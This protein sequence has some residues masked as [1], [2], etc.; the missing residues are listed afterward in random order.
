[1]SVYVLVLPLLLLFGLYKRHKIPSNT[2]D[3]DDEFIPLRN[4]RNSAKDDILDSLQFLD[5]NYEAKFWF[6]EL[7]EIARKFLLT[8]GI[9]YFG[10]KSLSGV[11][12]A[13]MIANVFLVLHAHFK[14]IKRKSEQ[15]LQLLSLTVISL[16]L[17]LGTLI[18]LQDA[19]S[20]ILAV[21]DA[22]DRKVFSI[23]VMLVNA[24]FVIFLL[25]RLVFCGY[26]AMKAVRENEGS[27][28]LLQWLI[29]FVTDEDT[30]TQTRLST[31]SFGQHANEM[32]AFADDEPEDK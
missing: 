17:M 10:G 5:E 12:I 21:E 27:C 8:C 28:K 24:L 14:P 3:D 15:L 25:G 1:M 20:N 32:S 29:F 7:L 2:S 9:E 13:A 18:A 31:Q 23:V 6:W 4:R 30:Q 22:Y 11:A 16:S 26:K 19:T